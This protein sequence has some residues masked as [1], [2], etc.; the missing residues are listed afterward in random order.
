QLAM[1]PLEFA[2]PVQDPWQPYGISIPHRAAPMDREA[3]SIQ[4]D[5]VD[6][7]R[8]ERVAL[9]QDSGSLV[10]Q[11]IDAAIDNLFGRDLPLLDP[12]FGG[13]FSD[14]VGHFRVAVG[15]AILIILVPARAG[16]LPVTAHLTQP[17]LGNRLAFTGLLQMPVLLA[18]APPDVQSGEVSSRHRPHRHAKVIKRF[19][20]CFDACPF[21]DQK[22]R[23]SPIRTKHPVT[24]KSS[25]I[26]DQHSYLTQLFRKSHA[27]RDDVLA[28]VLSAYYF[29]K[30]HHVRRAKK[31][32]PD[33][34]PG[35]RR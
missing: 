13:P 26:A 6:I 19:V 31:V 33:H 23:L 34:R 14:Q 12:G 7:D 21:L 22:L 11:G 29:E 30:P 15:P 25:T 2:N 3:I 20:D 4:V 35:P 18:N 16:L 9:F 10:D 27:G 8:S 1:A 32:C 24:D 17:V 28:A 5:D